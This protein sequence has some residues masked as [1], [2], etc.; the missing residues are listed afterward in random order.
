M[1]VVL[2]VGRCVGL[3]LARIMENLDESTFGA[4]MLK[5]RLVV[6]NGTHANIVRM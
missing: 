5:A 1:S 2:I 4:D 3:P 6:S